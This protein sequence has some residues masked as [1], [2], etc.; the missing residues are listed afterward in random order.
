MECSGLRY[1]PLAD[2]WVMRGY[3]NRGETEISIG[4]LD[5]DLDVIPEGDI[6][7]ELQVAYSSDFY[8]KEW[9]EKWIYPEYPDGLEET[10]EGLYYFFQPA[11]SGNYGD[12]I[13]LS[14]QEW[15][16][17]KDEL[18]KRMIPEEEWHPASVFMP[19]RHFENIAVG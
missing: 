8:D 2:G 3:S 7:L 15:E 17:V 14:V 1:L 6:Y 9:Y 16:A 12:R 10:G 5:K 11:D 19:V 4:R 18:E 13:W